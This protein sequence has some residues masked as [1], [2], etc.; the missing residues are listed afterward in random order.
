M[1]WF[2][3]DLPV[4]RIHLN[5]TCPTARLTAR[6]YRARICG[7]DF[8]C[9]TK[10]A[11]SVEAV[12]TS[13]NV[14]F[15]FRT[16]TPVVISA[17]PQNVSKN[18]DDDD[19]IMA[20]LMKYEAQVKKDT[21]KAPAGLTPAQVTTSTVVRKSTQMSEA[22]KKSTPTT[23]SSAVAKN[24]HQGSKSPHFCSAR[25]FF[26]MAAEFISRSLKASSFGPR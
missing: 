6:R 3:P 21:K 22:S 14:P 26:T 8:A 9:K 5:N 1:V 23:T 12:E 17:P 19:D 20:T 2:D 4:L 7:L 16:T 24:H 18:D 25:C 10:S 15:H 11:L 13:A